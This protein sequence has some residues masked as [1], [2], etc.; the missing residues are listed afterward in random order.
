MPAFI[1]RDPT[2]DELERFRL[3]MSLHRY[4]V[5]PGGQLKSGELY[6]HWT[7]IE[8][9]FADAFGGIHIPAGKG[10]YDVLL[11]HDTDP[12]IMYGIQVKSK[13]TWCG[14]GKSR[15]YIEYD[16]ANKTYLDGLRRDK[17]TPAPPVWMDP[18]SANSSTQAKKIG[19]SVMKTQHQTHSSAKTGHIGTKA[20][21]IIDTDKGKL[22][23]ITWS[24][25]SQGLYQYFISCWDYNI[26]VP[27]WRFRGKDPGAR[28]AGSLWGYENATDS[29][30]DYVAS[31]NFASRGQFKWFPLRSSGKEYS[32]GGKPFIVEAGPPGGFTWSG[33][34][35][36][37]FP[38]K[39]V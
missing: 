17:I 34:A 23:H 35:K 13:G 19:A 30:T 28:G 1:D 18:T 29:E 11:P 26:S 38:K 20:G 16:N 3:L 25:N 6:P 8:M 31:W 22:V 4:G 12:K 37:L 36:R 5:G 39:W 32:N 10:T 2:T 14:K 9:A 7:F 21:Q 24:H 33:L 15:A 27:H